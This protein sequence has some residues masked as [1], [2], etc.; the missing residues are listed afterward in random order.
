MEITIR[1]HKRVVN[2]SVDAGAALALRQ[3]GKT[4]SQIKAELNSSASLQTISRALARAEE[5]ANG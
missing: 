1:A 4:L 2:Y 3:Q 5:K